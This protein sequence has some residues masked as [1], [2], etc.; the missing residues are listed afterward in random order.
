MSQITYTKEAILA[1]L[2]VLLPNDDTALESW[3][4][5]KFKEY[6]YKHRKL[7]ATISSNT[8]RYDWVSKYKNRGHSSRSYNGRVI[9]SPL[10]L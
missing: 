4:E 1:Y 8:L 2:S 10:G 9:R 7:P 6:E 3:V 5:D